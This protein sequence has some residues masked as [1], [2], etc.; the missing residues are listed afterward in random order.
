M[1]NNLV[2]LLPAPPVN[3]SAGQYF[4]LSL[5]REK[6]G[7]GGQKGIET[8]PMR[9]KKTLA[10]WEKDL[11]ICGAAARKYEKDHAVHRQESK[12]KMCN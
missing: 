8:P 4:T 5:M 12:W 10:D 3:G 11:Q 6:K 9:Q 7:L 2:I 1:F